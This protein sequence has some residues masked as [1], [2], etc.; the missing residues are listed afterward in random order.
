MNPLG[1]DFQKQNQLRKETEKELKQM[2]NRIK[3]LQ[4]QEGKM[5]RRTDIQ[6]QKME[7]MKI[8]REQAIKD[9]LAQEERKKQ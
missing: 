7:Q 9:R 5:K 6:V 2:E 8:L 3:L 1:V 4:I